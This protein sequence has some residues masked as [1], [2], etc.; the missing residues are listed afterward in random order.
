MVRSRIRGRGRIACGDYFITR[1]AGVRAAPP[2]VPYH[3][4][5]GLFVMYGKGGAAG[6]DISSCG[7]RFGSLVWARGRE[8]VSRSTLHLTR[9]TR[10]V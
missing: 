10:R 6:I 4:G 3:A 1:R 7:V 2:L 9:P 5:H 8:R